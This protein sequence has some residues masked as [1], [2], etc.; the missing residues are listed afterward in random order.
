MQLSE[1]IQLIRNDKLS[2]ST[3]T[4]WADL[5]CGSGLFTYALSDFLNSGS[6]IYA[7]DKTNPLKP[8]KQPNGVEVIPIQKDFVRDPLELPPLDGIL[9]ANALH[10]VENK[11][12]FIDKLKRYLKPKSGFLIVEYDLDKPVPTWVPYP[13]S[14]VALTRLFKTAGYGSVEKL[15]ER[16]S[17]YGRG[18]MYA[19][20]IT[21]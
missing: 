16:P 4:D 9:M 8:E 10:Y 7:V 20:L 1:A 14:F 6:R 18:N 2:R 5:G 17:R 13:V 3:P 15:G 12:G 21:K 11:P 19:A